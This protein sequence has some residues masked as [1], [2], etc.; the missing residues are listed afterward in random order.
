MI[1]SFNTSKLCSCFSTE[2]NITF[3]LSTLFEAAGIFVNYLKCKSTIYGVVPN[4]SFRMPMAT[5]EFSLDKAIPATVR[6]AALVS[7]VKNN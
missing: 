3:T 5:L 4:L 2:S 7:L 6:Y 1:I